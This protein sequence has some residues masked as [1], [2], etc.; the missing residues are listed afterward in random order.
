MGNPITSNPIGP[1]L[2]AQ[3]QV[4]ALSLCLFVPPGTA[5]S[6]ATTSVAVATGP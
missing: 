5:A 1:V 2:R 3:Q 4:G 6:R